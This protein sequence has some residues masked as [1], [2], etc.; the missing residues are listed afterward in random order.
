V[1]GQ[2]DLLAA[3][4]GEREIGDLVVALG[5][6]GG[7]LRREG[8]G[9]QG[10]WC[11]GSKQPAILRSGSLFLFPYGPGVPRSRHRAALV[12]T[13]RPPCRSRPSTRPSRD[14]VGT[15]GASSRRRHLRR[16]VRPTGGARASVACAP[17]GQS[18]SARVVWPVRRR[19]RPVAIR[20]VAA[21]EVECHGC[22]KRVL[23]AMVLRF[24]RSCSLGRA[25]RV[26]RGSARHG[27]ANGAAS[28]KTCRPVHPPG[29]VPRAS[30]G[31]PDHQ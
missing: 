7:T 27:T 6:R 25:S 18:G 26:R 11:T 21:A 30:V 29:L 22:R 24:R 5:H 31:P 4:R 20:T 2:L 23:A 3:E 15:W 14:R 16:P 12:L 28:P 1:L 8:A 13:T 10:S 17:P 19:T 9:H